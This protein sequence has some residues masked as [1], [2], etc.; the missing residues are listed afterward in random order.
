MHT[1]ARKSVN[2]SNTAMAWMAAV[3][4]GLAPTV[5][6]ANEIAIS[7]VG[8][9]D[10]EVGA[11][12]VVSVAYRSGEPPASALAADVRFDRRSLARPRCLAGVALRGTAKAVQCAE[13]KPGVVRIIVLGLDREALAEGDL[14]RVEFDVV[15]APRKPNHWVRLRRTSASTGD[16]ES[17]RLRRRAPVSRIAA[18][19]G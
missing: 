18:G 4:L 6:Q 15:A 13:P 2:L 11:T 17:L 1:H 9:L 12:V 16:G 7:N 3:A 19:E 14:V 5:L 8:G 10:A